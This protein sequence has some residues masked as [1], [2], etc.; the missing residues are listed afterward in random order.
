V[1]VRKWRI[2][3]EFKANGEFEPEEYLE[4]FED[5]NLPFNAEIG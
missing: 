2:L 1:S 3:P 4:Y 5:S